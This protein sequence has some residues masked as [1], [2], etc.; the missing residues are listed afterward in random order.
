VREAQFVDDLLEVLHGVR[1][2]GIAA[3]HRTLPSFAR[4][5][6][7]RARERDSAYFTGRC[8]NTTG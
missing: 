2:V 8:L 1:S 7:Y 3:F 4:S 5:F 6:I